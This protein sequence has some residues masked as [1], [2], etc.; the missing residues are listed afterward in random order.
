MT[1]AATQL[2]DDFFGQSFEP[3]N[4]TPPIALTHMASAIDANNVT[5]GGTITSGGTLVIANGAVLDVASGGVENIQNGGSL[6]INSGGLANIQSGGQATIASGGSLTFAAGSTIT[7]SSTILNTGGV[8]NGGTATA[9]VLDLAVTNSVTAAGSTQA[10]GLALTTPVNNISSVA[11]A[12]GVNLLASA[13]GLIQLEMNEGAN[14]VLMYAAQ[15]NTVDV[16]NTIAGSIG[17]PAPVGSLSLLVS[18]VAGTIEAFGVNP[19]KVSITSDST[20]SAH[21]LAAS[22]FS[23]GDVTTVVN[24][25]GSIASGTALTLPTVANFLTA[26][27]WTSLNSGIVLRLCNSSAGAGG[28]TLTANGSFTTS[29]VSLVAQNTWK[30]WAIA[31]VNG[32]SVTA[33]YMGTGTF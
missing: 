11:A 23:T 28:W 25:T 26:L 33:T 7:N 20:T 19:K 8:I 5:T 18:P 9:L 30:E 31:V 13:A 15:G 1:T 29:G 6:L 4:T 17:V 12:T 21:T 24:M 22:V 16:I 3:Y 10:T 27:P 2:I 14:P 32:T